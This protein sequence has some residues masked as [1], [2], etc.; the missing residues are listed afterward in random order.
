MIIYLD[1]IFLLLNYYILLVSHNLSISERKLRLEAL[2]MQMRDNDKLISRRTTD[3]QVK[4]I[5][6]YLDTFFNQLL[7]LLNRYLD[8]LHNKRHSKN[9]NA[10][11]KNNTRHHKGGFYFKSLEDKGDQPLTGADLTKLLDEIQPDEIYNLAAQS[12]VR[13]SFDIPQFTVQ[14]NALGVL[15]ILEAYRRAC[16][17]AKFYQASSSEMFG[18]SV[19][20]DGIQRLTTPMNP[21]NRTDIKPIRPPGILKLACKVNCLLRNR[22]MAINIKPYI[23]IYN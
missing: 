5:V 23:N 22:M 2:V 8:S 19:D 13:V 11:I 15:N 17:K 16:P 10:S 20:E 9:T 14:T 12:H 21:A 1:L 6:N 3:I 4:N 18:N 7:I